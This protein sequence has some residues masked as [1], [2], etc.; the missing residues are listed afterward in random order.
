MIRTFGSRPLYKK[1]YLTQ[2][3]VCAEQGLCKFLCMVRVSRIGDSKTSYDS[4]CNLFK[5]QLGFLI[6]DS[7][8]LAYFYAHDFD[9]CIPQIIFPN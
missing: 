8:M 1:I 9:T 6:R 3:I 2:V 5:F 7:S 4:Y